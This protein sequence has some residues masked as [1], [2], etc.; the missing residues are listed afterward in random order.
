[1]RKVI[2]IG[3]V[4]LL[5][6]AAAWIFSRWDSEKELN[7]KT[8]YLST[9]EDVN[10]IRE[11]LKDSKYTY[12][13]KNDI[14]LAQ[15]D[16]WEPIV[17]PENRSMHLDGGGFKISGLK[18]SNGSRGG[19]F[20]TYRGSIENLD[21]EVEIQTIRGYFWI[22]AFAGKIDGATS[23]IVN[24]QSYGSIKTDYDDRLPGVGKPSFNEY[25]GGIVGYNDGAT[26]KNCTNYVNIDASMG[27]YVGG[28]TGYTTNVMT[29]KYEQVGSKLNAPVNYYDFESGNVINSKNYGSIMS[30]GNYVGGI[31]GYLSHKGNSIKHIQEMST[32]FKSSGNDWYDVA[33]CA[34]SN[35]NLGKVTSAGDYVGGIF[36]KA[37]FVTLSRVRYLDL[38]NYGEVEGYNYV[39]GIAGQISVSQGNAIFQDFTNDGHVTGN[40][41]TGGI[42]GSAISFDAI[43][44]GISLTLT[45]CR[46]YAEII[47]YSKVGGIVGSA[48]GESKTVQVWYKNESSILLEVCFGDGVV[49]FIHTSYASIIL[50]YGLWASSYQCTGTG[51]ETLYRT[52]TE[53]EE[54][55]APDEDNSLA[56]L[57]L[58]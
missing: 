21:L 9:A 5:V 10:N 46:N 32:Y 50:G 31:I 54:I 38:F 36:G 47:G 12:V 33:D 37:E 34:Y 43:P 44:S 26:I 1:M 22:G 45:A 17:L 16:P 13:L 30:E 52:P 23:K 39:G 29:V 40:E 58:T 20:S 55:I 8:V 14:S 41:E 49:K 51:Y 56:L 57:S 35:T 53:E 18:I 25:I 4:V 3:I 19:L 48:V 15:Y 2:T 27:D 28:I 6:V 7:D 24:C 11:T 42:F